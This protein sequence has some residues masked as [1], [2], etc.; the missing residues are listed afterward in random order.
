MSGSRSDVLAR[1]PACSNTS[2]NSRSTCRVCHALE[3]LIRVKLVIPSVKAVSQSRNG[4]APD[5]ES[6]ACS[7][8][9]TNSAS[10]PAN[11]TRLLLT[12]S[13]GSVLPIRPGHPRP[14]RRRPR[15][16]RSR[17][18]VCYGRVDVVRRPVFLVEAPPDFAWRTQR[19]MDSRSSSASPNRRRTGSVS[20][21]V[22][23][24][25]WLCRRPNDQLG[26]HRAADWSGS[27][28]VGESDPQPVGGMRAEHPVAEPEVGHDQRCVRL[29]VRDITRMSRG[30]S[31]GSSWSRPTS[32]SR[33]RRLGGTGRGSCAPGPTGHLPR[34]CGPVAGAALARCRAVTSRVGCYP[35][36][37]GDLRRSADRAAGSLEFPGVAAEPREQRMVDLALTGVHAARDAPRRP[38][39][40]CHA[41]LSGAA[42]VQSWWVESACSNS[43]SVTARRVWP[44]NE[45]RAGSPIGPSA[46]GDRLVL[47]DMWGIRIDGSTSARQ[48]AGCQC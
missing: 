8:R 2:A 4:L 40:F 15:S 12:S 42:T 1:E 13:S 45:S 47:A 16:G 44:N 33:R 21:S 26:G 29:D 20:A 31:V 27:A 5:S 43:I 37:V 41:A 38:A 17:N 35:G 3:S 39:S 48:S 6:A 24:R 19:V 10:C 7:S 22:P 32:T 28:P 9:Q 14:S 18:A 11:S 30:S 34:A 36:P 46:A 23:P 25:P